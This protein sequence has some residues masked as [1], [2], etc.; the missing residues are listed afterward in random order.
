LTL[1]VEQ[2]TVQDQS[3]RRA[4]AHVVIEKGLDA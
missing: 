4:E 2:V 1:R 3:N